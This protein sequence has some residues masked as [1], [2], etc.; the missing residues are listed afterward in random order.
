ML[1]RILDWFF[2]RFQR[3]G[4]KGPM[5]DKV[6]QK[7]E[8]VRPSPK[9]SRPASGRQ[10]IDTLREEPTNRRARRANA[11]R[12]KAARKRRKG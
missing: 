7:M 10:E 12:D 2:E 11:A 3:L 4:A 8:K 9:P 5:A 1:T 6:R